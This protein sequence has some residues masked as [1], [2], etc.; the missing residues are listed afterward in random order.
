MSVTQILSAIEQGDPSRAEELL[1]LVYDELRKLAAARMA[2]EKPGQ[3]LQATVLVHEVYLKMADQKRL[4]ARDR[5]HFLAISA[6]AIRRLMADR[7]RRRR[8]R[9]L[10]VH[11]VHGGRGAAG[12]LAHRHRLLP[13]AHGHQRQC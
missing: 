11:E 5:G 2:Q 10:A 9:R 13:R 4:D 7:A 8:R 1:P 3:T 6:H 12:D